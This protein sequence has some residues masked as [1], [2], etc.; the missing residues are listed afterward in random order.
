VTENVATTIDPSDVANMAGAAMHHTDVAAIMGLTI[1]IVAIV[2]GI[3]VAMLGM[4]LDFRKK[5]EMFQ[6]HHAER[7]AAIEKGVDIPPLPPEFF[8]GEEKKDKTP[9]TYFRRGVMWLLIGIAATAALWG[10]RDNDFWWG[11]VPAAVGVAYLITFLVE[12]GRERDSNNQR[13]PL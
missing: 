9:Y 3:G 11:L 6:L 10:T 12:R 13:T 5:R 1:P 4:W 8:H 7:M 2:M